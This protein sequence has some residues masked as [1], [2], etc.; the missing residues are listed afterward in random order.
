MMMYGRHEYT[1][2]FSTDLY[3]TVSCNHSIDWTFRERVKRSVWTSHEVRLQQI[4]SLKQLTCTCEPRLL[5]EKNR[6]VTDG[7]IQVKCT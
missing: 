1:Y 5:P 2:K 3:R 6:C 7:S 4:P